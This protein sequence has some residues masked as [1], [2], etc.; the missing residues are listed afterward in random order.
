[1]LEG[2]SAH[3]YVFGFR[4]IGYTGP[5]QS[6]HPS[7][8]LNLVRNTTGEGVGNKTQH[9]VWGWHR[10]PCRSGRFFGTAAGTVGSHFLRDHLHCVII[11]AVLVNLYVDDGMSIMCCVDSG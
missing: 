10:R 8:S 6:G 2:R 5:L 3:S 7:S 9:Y 1:M 4:G 11:A